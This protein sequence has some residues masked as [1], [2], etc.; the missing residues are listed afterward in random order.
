MDEHQLR[1]RVGAW[2]ENVSQLADGTRHAV[3]EKYWPAIERTLR[4]RVL[5][6]T[7]AFASDDE[8]VTAIAETAYQALPLALRLLFKQTEFIAF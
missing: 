1:E 8:R 4:G 5:P 2:K 7:L 6:S 3:V